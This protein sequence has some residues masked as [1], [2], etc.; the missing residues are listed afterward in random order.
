MN[1]LV[2]EKLL[3]VKER[4]NNIASLT[5]KNEEK[6]NL[7]ENIFRILKVDD[8]EIRHS[9]FLAWLLLNNKNFLNAFLSSRNLCGFDENT[10]SKLSNSEYLVYREYRNKKEL[11]NKSLD[12]VIDFSKYKILIVIEN[13]IYA[14]EGENQLKDYYELIENSEEFESY[15]KLYFYL[16]LNGV[17]PIQKEDREH[18]KSIS[19]K[20]I[21]NILKK[22]KLTTKSKVEYILIKNYI[23]ILT[24]KIK[25]PTD[26]VKEYFE[27][28]KNN[29]EI[30]TE[31]ATYIPNI[32]ARANIVRE[33]LSSVPKL[34]IV[35]S[36]QN[37]YIYFQN[38]DVVDCFRLHNLP[39]NW[40]EF[41]ISNEPCDKCIFC[42]LINKDKEKVFERFS[43]EFR[44][45][46]QTEDKSRSNTYMHLYSKTLVSNPENGG[47]LT[48]EEFEQ[49][50][51]N[52]LK[53]FI[54]DINSEFNKI[55]N[56]ILSYKFD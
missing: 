16:T 51:L 42:L 35:S 23:E 7:N 37:T 43:Q 56:F 18:W 32:K 49:E 39:D 36:K 8:L 53:I 30:V 20:D 19:Y 1:K 3:Q 52:R 41:C 27:I 9:N 48:E 33:Y 24:E 14:T 10:C 55:V 22:I 5:F 26:R 40:I 34:R 13:K 46:F 21:L 4:I 15:K 44:K 47:Y 38:S 50:M 2:D 6:Y 28:Y 31:M 17:S 12:I 54:E 45:T 29:K 11:N 25:M